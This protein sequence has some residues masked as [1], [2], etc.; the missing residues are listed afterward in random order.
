[1]SLDQWVSERL[2][3]YIKLS[4]DE[5]REAVKELVAEGRNN[6][7][8]GDILGS[9]GRTVRRDLSA[10]AE[11]QEPASNKTNGLTSPNSTNAEP[12][13]TDDDI[14]SGRELSPDNH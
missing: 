9:D 13:E 7:E 4:I 3:G 1:M 10:N 2:G 12:P 11:P 6:V 8:V 5:R 14:V